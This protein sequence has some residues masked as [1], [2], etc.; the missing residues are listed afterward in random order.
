VKLT[1]TESLGDNKSRK[2][3]TDV[4]IPVN[5]TDKQIEA[6]ETSTELNGDGSPKLTLTSDKTCTDA[7]GNELAVCQVS[8]DQ[9]IGLKYSGNSGDM[10][11]YLW[12][13]DGNAFNCNS[14]FNADCAGNGGV[15]YFPV[16]KEAGEQI[17]V[18][19]DATNQR[20]GEKVSLTKMFEVADPQIGISCV[21]SDNCGQT[22]LGNYIDL[23]GKKWPDYS[24]VNYWANTGNVIHLAASSTGFSVPQGGFLWVVDGV[25]I[26]TSTAPSYGYVINDDGSITLPPKETGDSYDVTAGIVYT[27]DN[28]VKK[29][30]NE[31]W[32]VAYN[33]FYEKP[34]SAS[35][36]I[37][38]KDAG[39]ASASAGNKRILASVYA[40]L[41][42]YFAFIFRIVLTGLI[43]LVG[44]SIILSLFPEIKNED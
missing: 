38:M 33:Q 31:Y 4:I 27:Q 16:L 21:D 1:A 25:G 32:N 6:F 36:S 13:I 15:A 11:D 34:I 41:P 20:T 7:D 23:D 40:S 39:F 37:E 12:T 44:S 17:P 43:L 24:D 8:K 35:I 42:S 18:E 19:L 9:I 30:L 26:D 22:L 28:A 14:D 3:V 29:A 5:T 10:T 2:G